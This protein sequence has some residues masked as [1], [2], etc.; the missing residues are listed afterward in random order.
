[1]IKKNTILSTIVLTIALI[2]CD[3]TYP[4][5]EGVNHYNDIYTVGTITLPAGISIASVDGDSSGN[6]DLSLLQQGSCLLRVTIN[7]TGASDVNVDLLAGWVFIADD[8]EV[9]DM[10]IFQ[11]IQVVA[12][13]GS[14]VVYVPTFCVDPDLSLPDSSDT[15]EMNG[16]ITQ[17]AL[18]SVITLLETKT[19]TLTDI[20]SIMSIIYDCIQSG[21]LSTVNQATL[22]AL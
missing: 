18:Q 19:I 11:D 17:S 5:G 8:N 2:S 12:T 14:T 3:V 4:G 21:S 15:F 7:N 16:T 9:Q 10:G 6:S 13:P 1:M 22:N 20:A